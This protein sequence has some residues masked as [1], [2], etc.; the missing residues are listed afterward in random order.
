M[1][2][3]AAEM[4]SQHFAEAAWLIVLKNWHLKGGGVRGGLGGRSANLIGAQC[5]A[6]EMRQGRHL[7]LA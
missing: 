1:G 5:H 6:D 3:V 7:H 4:Q 2:I